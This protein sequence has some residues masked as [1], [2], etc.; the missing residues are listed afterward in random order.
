MLFIA[1]EL[2]GHP[3]GVEIVRA[4][5]Q[6]WARLVGSCNHLLKYP[7]RAMVLPELAVGQ[8]GKYI[9]FP[10]VLRAVALRS[11]F[12]CLCRVGGFVLGSERDSQPVVLLRELGLG[13]PSGTQVFGIL[14]RRFEVLCGLFRC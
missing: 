2:R 7:F 13:G 5:A 3:G 9:G 11:G 14:H 12:P 6:V 8:S 4:W 10:V 1:L